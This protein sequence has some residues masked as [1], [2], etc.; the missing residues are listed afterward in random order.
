M[1]LLD[2]FAIGAR[3]PTTPQGLWDGAFV[4]GLRN[5][6]LYITCYKDNEAKISYPTTHLEIFVAFDNCIHNGWVE[7]SDGDIDDTVGLLI[8]ELDLISAIRCET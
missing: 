4:G 6:K 5:R 1:S 3:D 8:I 2:D 7:M